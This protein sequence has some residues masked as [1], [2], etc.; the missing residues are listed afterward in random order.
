MGSQQSLVYY[1]ETGPRPTPS[2]STHIMA[3]ESIP[4]YVMGF[5]KSTHALE[6]DP[7]PTARGSVNTPV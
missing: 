7:G 3:E 1:E 5:K 2:L 6:I 4:P